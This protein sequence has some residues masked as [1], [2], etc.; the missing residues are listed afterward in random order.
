MRIEQYFLITNY[1]LWEVILNGDSPT[2]NRIVDGVV[3]VIAPTTAEQRIA[4]KNELKARGTLLIALSDKHQLKFNIHKDVKSLMEAIEKRPQLENEDLKQIDADYLEEMDLK[5]QM[6]MLTMRARRLN[7]TIAIEEAIFLENADHQKDNRN[8]DNPRRTIPVE[9]STLNALVSQC[10]AVGSYD[11]SF[12]TSFKN[13]SKLLESQV[14]DKTSLGYDS[15]VFNSQVFD[16]EEVHSYESDDSVPTSLVNDRYKSGEGYHDVHPPYTRTF[17]PPKPDLVFNDAPNVSETVTNVVHVESSLNK[18]SKDMSKTLQPDAP[19]VEDWTSDSKD[20][21]ELESVPKQKEPSF[22]PTSKDVKTPRASVKLVEH[23]KQTENLRTDN[24]KSRDFDY[25]EKEMA[26]KPVWNHAMSVTYQNSTRMTHPH[27]NRNVVPTTVLTRSGLVS[28]NAARPVPTVVPYTTMKSTRPVK[29]VVNKAHSPIRSPINHIPATKNSNFNQKVTAVKVN[30]VNA[31]QGTKGNWIQVS[32]GLGLQKTLSFLFDVQSN[33]HQALKDKGVIDSGCLRHITGNIY[34]LLDFEEFNG[35]YAAFGGN[36]KSGKISGKGKIKTSKLDFNDVYFVK[37]LKFN[38]FGVLQMC[39]KK[40]SVL[41]TDTECVVL[42]SDFKLPDENHVLLRVP[43]ENMYNVDL[44]NFVPSGDLTCLFAKATLDDK[45]ET[46][47]IFKTFVTGIDNQINH[48]VKIIRCNNGTKFKNHDLNQFCE[49]KGIKIE[50]SVARTPQQNGVA[51]RKNRTFIEATRTKLAHSL[52]PIL[53]WAKA[54]NIACYVQNRVLVTKPYN[55][56]PYE[57]LLGRTPSICFMRHFECPVTILNTLDPLG[58]FDRKANEGF[59][60]GYTVNSKAFRGVDLN[61]YL[62]LIL[63]P[64]LGIINQLLQGINLIIMKN[65]DAAFD[66]KEN[67]NEVHVSP[68][69]S[70]KTKK[71]DDKAKRDAKGKSPVDSPTRVRDLRA[72]F[73][74]F[75]SNN[76]NRVSAASAPVNAVGPNLTNSTNSFN[77]ASPYDTA[78]SPNFRIAGKSLFRDPSHYPDDPDMP[79]LED[80]VYSD[81]EEDVGVE[82]DL[83][84][85]ETNIYVNPIP[86]TKVHKDHP[87]EGIDYDEVFTLVERIEA[88][89][90]FLAYASFMG[91]MV[92]QM[93]VKNVFLYGTIE[94]EVYVCRPP[95]FEDP[96]YPDKVYKVVKALYG[97]HQVPRAWYETLTNYLLENG[98]Q[99]G[100]I[101]Q[102]LFIQKQKGLQVKQKDDGI[103]ISQDKYVAK[104]LR[105]FGFTDV[106]SASTPIE[107]KKHLLKDHDGEDVDVHIYRSMIGSLM[108]LNLSKPDIMFVVCACARFQVTPKVSYLHAVKRIFKYLKGKPHLGLWYPKDSPFNLVAYSNR[109]YAGASLDRKSTTGGCQFLGCRMISWQCKKQIVVAT[110]STEAKYVAAAMLRFYGFKISCWTMG[111]NQIVDFLNAQVI[112][113]ALMVNPTIYVSYIKKFWATASI[114]KV[115]D[116]VKL[117]ALI[118]KKKVVIT[119]DVIRQDLCLDDADGCISAKRTAWNEFS[120]SITSAI[121]CLTTED[122]DDVEVLAAPTLPSPTN[123]PLPAPHDPIL[124]SPQAQPTTPSSPPQE[125]PTDTSESFMTLLNNLMETCATLSQKVAELEQDKQTQALEIP[126]LKKRVK[127]LEKNRKSKHSGLKRLKKVGGKIKA[128]DADGDITLVDA[129]T[130]ADMDA[131]LQGRIDDDRTATIDVNAIESTVFDDE[132]VTMTMAQTLIKMNAKKARLLDEQIAKRLHDEEVKQAATREK[133]EQDDLER[134]QEIPKS[135]EETIFHSSSQEEYDNI[136]K[137]YGGESFKKLK[138]VEVSGSEST[139]DTPTNDP[140]EI[141]KNYPLS[142]EVMTLMLS[143]KL[144]VEEDSDMARDLVMKIFMEANKPKSRSKDDSAAEVMKKLL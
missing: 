68:S 2:P 41:F 104:T 33:P 32:H 61:G 17:M 88:I 93:D 51:E 3:Q 74:E 119:K 42:F 135:Q 66:V 101:D 72:K 95:G 105:K 136:F 22:V 63:L 38:L 39:D 60:V 109:Y 140:K 35:G 27:S 117:Q 78:V 67:E 114:K 20:K 96:D 137:E 90:L 115:N 130:Q 7:V 8:K 13:L 110:S 122:E 111:F 128:T 1:S 125:Q 29:H 133:Q 6:A 48:K 134:D 107:T 73:E 97:L 19:I 5:W 102:T 52:L 64:S 113:Y 142:N 91:F 54:V 4:K 30:K 87:E 76:T 40:N 92:Y 120:C 10:D 106:K 143:E 21:T 16:C 83:S 44:K 121:I 36:P 100:K 108:Y 12:Q 56:T 11:W 9:V 131:E 144:Q 34:F 23:P 98:F 47:T 82:A 124:T 53:F 75:S 43:R 139:Q 85:L 112:Q 129:E 25:Y 89:W 123:A 77:T 86:T 58:K 62:I 103:F 65:T 81:Y 50:F 141:K 80:I 31:V 15:Q 138:A 46:S 24:Q 45:D 37:D 132:D 69:G 59:L 49:I 71:H 118:D 127:K 26:Q 70:D 14:N 55:K 28:L 116:V 57:L 18:P 99:K 79:A 94:E 84:N 126:K